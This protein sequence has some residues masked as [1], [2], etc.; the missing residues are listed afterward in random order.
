VR[1]LI[2]AIEAR[3]ETPNSSPQ[4]KAEMSK[5]ALCGF[6]DPTGIITPGCEGKVSHARL[7]T[8]S[9][10]LPVGCVKKKAWRIFGAFR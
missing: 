6:R 1:F 10:N 2:L 8:V 3:G 9:I 4:C 5:Q 7:S